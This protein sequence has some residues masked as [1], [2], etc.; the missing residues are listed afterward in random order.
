MNPLAF[1]GAEDSSAY[2]TITDLSMTFRERKQEEE[3][4]AN[5][6]LH[7]AK[8]E[9]VSII[10]PSGSGKSTLFHLIGGL[11][12][13]TS[14]HIWLEGQEI[15]GKVG[16]VSY[17]PQQHALLP[18]RTVRDNVILSCELAGQSRAKARKESERW[19]ARAG[20]GEYARSYP[21]VLSGGMKQRASFIR[22][23]LSPQE[24][25]LLDEPFGSLD[26]LTRLDMQR[27]LLDLWE[28]EKRSVLFITHSID[29]A[30]LLSDRVYVFSNKPTTILHEIQVPFARPRPEE[31]PLH[32]EFVALKQEI[33]QTMKAERARIT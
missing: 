26:D 25:L 32:P 29:E 2:L 6:N 16:L 23:L 14:G 33:Y 19:L 21:H 5:I 8:G 1:S 4:L 11:L 20:L 12:Q 17:M 15:T 27:W 3:V 28:D 30:L 10:G 22:A 9:F 31:L 24:L 7:V 18:W 13:P